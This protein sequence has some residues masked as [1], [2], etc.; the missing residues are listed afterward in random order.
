[1]SDTS[2][3]QRLGTSTD[4]HMLRIRGWRELAGHRHVRQ[5]LQHQG[6]SLRRFA[7]PC[8]GALRA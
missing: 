5:S 7:V 8:I 2:R 1:M 3:R 6:Q 4:T